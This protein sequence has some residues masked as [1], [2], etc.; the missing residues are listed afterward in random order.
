MNILGHPYVA[1]KVTGRI[2]K[3]LVA[4][5]HLP[6]LVPFVPNS[7]FSFEEIHEGGDKFL[8]F[9]K[10]NY[11][12]KTDLALGMIIHSVKYG[13]DKFNREV[14]HWLLEG[15]KNLKD[16]LTREIVDCS[17]ISFEA[18][19]KYRLHNYLWVGVDMFLL[20]NEP[21]FTQKLIEAHKQIDGREIS[22]LLAEGYQKDPREVE[23][24][25]D[26]MFEPIKQEMPISI[27]GLVKLWK[28]CLAG[29]P[30]K[31]I[32]NEQKTRQLFN[33]I[34]FMFE[35]QW[36]EIISRVVENIKKEYD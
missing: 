6:D 11:P 35:K 24:M 3:Y 4:G 23:K 16:E 22:G 26:Y 31:D 18:A 12:N 27:D 32:V 36:R 8:E 7:V 30:E 15:N 21:N 9:L 28:I 5:S 14:E 25:V 13:A 10:E 20:K 33:K 19:G 1:Y 17:G 29:L 34:Y 2:N